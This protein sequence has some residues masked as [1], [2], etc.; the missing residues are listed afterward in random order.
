M[1]E[2]RRLILK[3]VADGRLSVDEAERLLSAVEGGPKQAE[4]F[5]GAPYDFLSRTAREVQKGLLD[6]GVQAGEEWRRAREKLRE[7]SEKLRRQLEEIQRQMKDQTATTD[8]TSR[9]HTITVEVEDDEGDTSG[10]E[11]SRSKGGPEGGDK[12]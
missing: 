6:I 11:G 3:M 1:S 4:R 2:E 12:P 9:D 5:G 8:R 7:R 10:S